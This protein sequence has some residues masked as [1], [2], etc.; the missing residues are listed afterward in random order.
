MCVCEDLQLVNSLMEDGRIV[1]GRCRHGYL[2][3]PQRASNGAGFV[4]WTTS[5]PNKL[6]VQANRSN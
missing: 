4:C 1:D 2:R 3:T 5:R 6:A